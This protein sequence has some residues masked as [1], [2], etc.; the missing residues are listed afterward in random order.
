MT[1]EVG[2]RVRT[3]RDVANVD[4]RRYEPESFAEGRA[5]MIVGWMGGDAVVSFDDHT[6]GVVPVDAIAAI[7]SRSGH[8][9]YRR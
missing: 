1:F 3:T 5:G 7:E 6:S 2:Q 8:R 4:Q 9:E